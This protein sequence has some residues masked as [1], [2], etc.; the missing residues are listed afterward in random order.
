MGFLSELGKAFM[1]KPLGPAGNTQPSGSDRDAPANTSQASNGVLDERGRKILPDIEIDNVDS[2]RQG[3]DGLI[4][5]VRIRNNSQVQIRIDTS[6]L[7]KQ[8]ITHN[9][10]L[11]PG[12]S[13]ELRLYNGKIPDNENERSAQIAYRLQVNN[14]VFMENFRINYGLESDGKRIIEDLHDDGPVRDI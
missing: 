8:K 2:D 5:K 3:S 7:L 12:E 13:R 9:Q 1:G 14:D 11:K 4:V 6:Y 10:F